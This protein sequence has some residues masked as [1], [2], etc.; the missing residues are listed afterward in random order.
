MTI[1]ISNNNALSPITPKE[2]EQL[3]SKQI[4][5]RLD[6]DVM[7]LNGPLHLRRRKLF[8]FIVEDHHHRT[9]IL[10]RLGIS[11]HD[12]VLQLNLIL[13]IAHYNPT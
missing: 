6:A 10:K 2:L 13:F 8:V 11:E 4:D 9:E 1:H 3:I 12:L 5:S 7:V